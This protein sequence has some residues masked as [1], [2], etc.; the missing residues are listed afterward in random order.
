MPLKTFLHPTL[1]AVSSAALLA[2]CAG[3]QF[4]FSPQNK[5]LTTSS[6]NHFMELGPCG[7]PW[8]YDDHVTLLFDSD[9]FRFEPDQLEAYQNGKLKINSGYVILNPTNQ[10]VTIELML[11]G[12]DNAPVPCKYNGTHKFTVRDPGNGEVTRA[13]LQNFFKTNAPDFY[14][15]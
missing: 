12:Y 3:S 10:T 4:V 2:G 1:A 5:M 11:E 14:Q 6:Y 9:G 13:W 15:P 7:S 8:N